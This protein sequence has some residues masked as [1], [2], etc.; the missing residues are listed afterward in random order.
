LDYGAR[1]NNPSICRFSSIDRFDGKYV[2]QSPYVYAANNPIRFIHMNG[3]SI[4]IY[5]DQGNYM[6]TF[7][8][9][10]SGVTGLIFQSSSSYDDGSCTYSDPPS[11]TYN[12][13]SNDRSRAVS[14]SYS[15]TLISSDEIESITDAGAASAGG[16]IISHYNAGREDGDLDYYGKENS[17]IGY[18]TLNIVI[19][20]GGG[21]VAYNPN[22]IILR[23]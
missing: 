1:L 14:G 17:P 3:D 19:G 7:D 6:W 11:F 5:D 18:N 16:N 9:G 21:S 8:D 23:H 15:L 10:K 22:C 2:G 4:D 20:G 12:D 13:E